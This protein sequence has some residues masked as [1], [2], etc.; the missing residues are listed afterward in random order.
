MSADNFI[1]EFLEMTWQNPF[2]NGE[3]VLF[4]AV[5]F[6]LIVNNGVIGIRIIRS[7]ERGKGYGSIGLDWLCDLADKHEVVMSGILQPAG[8]TRPRLTVRQLV[9]WY[10]SRG[11]VVEGRLICR[12][13]MTMKLKQPSKD[14]LPDMKKKQPESFGIESKDGL[15]LSSASSWR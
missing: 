11:F 13:P 3:R 5:A 2:N 1:A 6:E 7:L 9:K 15:R 10:T 8:T 12:K 4:H 14:T